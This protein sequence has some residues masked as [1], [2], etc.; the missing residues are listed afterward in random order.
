[1]KRLN[2]ATFAAT[3]LLIS[4]IALAQD[5]PA[6]G[7]GGRGRHMPSVD[8]QTKELST[9]LQ[10]SDDQTKQVRAILQDQ[11]DARQKL[12]QDQSTSFEEKRPK[13]REI[14]ETA[15]AKIRALLTNDQKSKYDQLEKE[16]Q[17]RRQHWKEQKD[18]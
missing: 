13:M 5:Q 18:S 14:H 11:Q 7:Q 4:L 9:T 8:D 15:S 12:M 10:L 1:M 16:Q 2:P 3:V 6:P 17:E